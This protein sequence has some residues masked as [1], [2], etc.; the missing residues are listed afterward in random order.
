MDE[1]SGNLAQRNV[2]LESSVTPNHALRLLPSL[3]GEEPFQN[4]TLAGSIMWSS[5][6]P[7]G[8]SFVSGYCG[9]VR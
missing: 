5:L 8:G 6:Y 7:F 1:G 3:A 2:C 9:L 4:I